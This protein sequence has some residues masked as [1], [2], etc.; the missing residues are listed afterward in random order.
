LSPTR[1]GK[2]K[3]KKKKKIYKKKTATHPPLVRFQFEL[4]SWH[5]PTKD[6]DSTLPTN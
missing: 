5:F 3:K 2:K 6:E 4:F 1:K